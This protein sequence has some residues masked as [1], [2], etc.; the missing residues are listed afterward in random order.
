MCTISVQSGGAL[1]VVVVV[2][3]MVVII[4]TIMT[5]IYSILVVI[6]WNRITESRSTP[7]VSLLPP[8]MLLPQTKQHSNSNLRIYQMY[9]VHRLFSCNKIKAFVDMRHNSLASNM[10]SFTARGSLSHR[11][12][13]NRAGRKVDDLN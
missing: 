8:Q 13:I 6:I 5:I 11:F 7:Y 2:L 10:T 3:V 12:R 1:V 9:A 4:T